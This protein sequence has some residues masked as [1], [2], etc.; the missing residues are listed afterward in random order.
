MKNAQT[1]ITPE[2]QDRINALCDRFGV[3]ESEV[4]TQAVIAGLQSL[5]FRKGSNMT[6]P[7]DEKQ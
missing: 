4:M 6:F 5:E 3:S 7:S 1:T 2:M